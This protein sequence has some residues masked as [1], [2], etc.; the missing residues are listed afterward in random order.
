MTA[1]SSIVIAVAF[2]M[3]PLLTSC[4]IGPG[5]DRPP[6][7][8]STFVH[9]LLDLHL[10]DAQVALGNSRGTTGENAPE[11][12]SHAVSMRDSILARHEATAAEFE[13][14]VSWWASRPEQFLTLYED[15]LERINRKSM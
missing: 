2:L 9:V 13:E 10:V 14:T 11:M 15:V 5:T 8:D 3:L 1:P 4:S 6:L 7:D 12:S